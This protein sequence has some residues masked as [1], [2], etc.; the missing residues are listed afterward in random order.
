MLVTFPADLMV[1]P[2]AELCFPFLAQQSAVTVI[3]IKANPKPGSKFIAQTGSTEDTFQFSSSFFSFP[4]LNPGEGGSVSVSNSS[5]LL[6]KNE[7]EHIS[8]LC[9]CE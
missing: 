8:G 2:D 5:Q 4:V 6:S 7:T 3:A 1:H 9:C